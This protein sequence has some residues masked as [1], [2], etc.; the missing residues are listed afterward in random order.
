MSSYASRLE[1]YR[2]QLESLETQK[3]RAEKRVAELNQEIENVL[4][5][6]S[7]VQDAARRTQEELRFHIESIVTMALEAVFAEPY[8]F[9]LDFEVKRNRTE[10][11][12]WF[13][14]YGERVS[15]IDATG[16]GAV[17]IAAFALRVTM[18]S[19]G[20]SRPTIILDE[21]FRFV[22]RDLQT[23]AGD[24]MKMLAEKL[25]LQFIMV[26]H[27][28][29]LIDAADK[30]VRVRLSDGVSSVDIV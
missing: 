5:A 1:R 22:S 11:Q 3:E 19:L 14:R 23:K 28:A 25:G 18:W 10:A 12:C 16:G 24:M 13:E 30:V 27:N 29:D 9:V 2:G 6:Q 17:D 15:P 8:T 7:I 4:L 20:R 26:T 21:P